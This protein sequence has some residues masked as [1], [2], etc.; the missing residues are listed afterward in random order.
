M[1]YKYKQLYKYKLCNVYLDKLA[2]SETHLYL[3][4]LRIEAGMSLDQLGYVLGLSSGSIKRY[5]SNWQQSK[6]PRWYELMLR[7]LSGDL[8]FYSDQWANCRISPHNKQLSIP[9]NKY[10]SFLPRELTMEYNRIAQAASHE[11]KKMQSEIDLL[12]NQVNAL[13]QINTKLELEKEKL[14]IKLDQIA[15]REKGIKTGKVVSLFGS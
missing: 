14:A 2:H 7:F 11:L 9:F 12:T 6:P 8:S 13:K 5:E 3:K 1:S 4:S 15:A 10:Q